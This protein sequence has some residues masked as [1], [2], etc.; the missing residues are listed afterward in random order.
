MNTFHLFHT[1]MDHYREMIKIDKPR[2]NYGLNGIERGRRSLS[3]LRRETK[4]EM[5]FFRLQIAF[6]T[7]KEYILSVKSMLTSTDPLIVRA[8]TIIKS[9]FT[10]LAI[11]LFE[12]SV[13]FID[14]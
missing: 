6:S 13:F 4:H 12:L 9:S 5:I 10:R 11:I 3:I 2:R 1:K 8:A 14:R 7:F